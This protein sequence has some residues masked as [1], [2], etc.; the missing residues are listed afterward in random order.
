MFTSLNGLQGLVIFILLCILNS[1]VRR[2]YGKAINRI[3]R[4]IFCWSCNGESSHNNELEGQDEIQNYLFHSL[5]L[6]SSF[7]KPSNCSF[8]GLEAAEPMISFNCSTLNP[9][10]QRMTSKNEVKC[11]KTDQSESYLSNKREYDT[12]T[13]IDGNRIY[14]QDRPL[15]NGEHIYECIEDENGMR[16]MIISNAYRKNLNDNYQPQLQSLDYKPLFFNNSTLSNH[17]LRRSSNEQLPAIIRDNTKSIFIPDSKLG[18]F[19]KVQYNK[20]KDIM[21]RIDGNQVVTCNATEYNSKDKQKY[22]A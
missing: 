6:T 16:K 12:K 21:A 17:K 14:N 7:S 13:T 15:V 22:N 19:K 18:F 9:S 20:T 5:N 8:N 3:C 10:I 1:S 2:K 11:M 4:T